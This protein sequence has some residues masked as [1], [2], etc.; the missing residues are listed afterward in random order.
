MRTLPLLSHT[1]VLRQTLTTHRMPRARHELEQPTSTNRVHHT[2]ITTGL[3]RHHS[4]QEPV[5][6]RPRRGTRRLGHRDTATNRRRQHRRD[7]QSTA[8]TDGTTV[9]AS[10]RSHQGQ[11]K[12][13]SSHLRSQLSGS[14]QKAAPATLGNRPIALRGF[15]PKGACLRRPGTS[16]PRSRLLDVEAPGEA[17]F[18]VPPDVRS[19]RPEARQQRYPPP[20]SDFYSPVKSTTRHP[21]ALKSPPPTTSARWN[22]PF[23]PPTFRQRQHPATMGLEPPRTR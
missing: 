23:I 3:T 15:T 19:P 5:R 21:G 6:I 13:P 18:G 8:T 2:R 12:Y 11:N 22:A 16:A 9:L 1:R 17:G 10:T 14:I 4:T 7:Q 20:A